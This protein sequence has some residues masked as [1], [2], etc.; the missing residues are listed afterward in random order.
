MSVSY[1]G[2]SITFEDGSTVSSGWNG[3]KNRI[4]N[5][6]ITIVQRYSGAAANN[7]TGNIYVMDRWAFN[8]QSANLYSARM[9]T[10]A[11]TAVSNYEADAAPTGFTNSIKITSLTA[12]TTGTGTLCA[13]FQ[14]I[15]GNNVE[16]FAWGTS[17]AKPITVSFW[18]KSSIAGLYSFAIINGPQTRCY[19]TTYRIN[20]ANTWEYK[21]ITIPGNTDGTWHKDNQVGMYLFWG[22]AASTLYGVTTNNVWDSTGG[23]YHATGTTR[24]TE[25]LNATMYITGVQAERGSTASSF[26][27]RSITTELAMCQRYY[28]QF[29][30][31]SLEAYQGAGGYVRALNTIVPLPVEMRATPTRTVIT[32][33][34]SSIIRPTATDY[35]G[36][37]P[38]SPKHLNAFLETNNTTGIASISGRTEGFSAEL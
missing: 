1:G 10:N 34:S 11:N 32:A 12:N 13:A 30:S 14:A 5:G 27:Y 35:S 22:F 26:E 4:I 25:T 6:T 17:S 8:G 20:Q 15:E 3:F 24:L 2:D 23:K 19:A 29:N 7:I 18:T 21:T 31:F 38:V 33:G 37:N 9:V 36:L 28:T 16:D